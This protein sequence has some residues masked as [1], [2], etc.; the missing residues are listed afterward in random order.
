MPLPIPFHPHAIGYLS[1]LITPSRSIHQHQRLP[2]RLDRYPTPISAPDEE[3]PGTIAW[4][5]YVGRRAP[6]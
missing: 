6:Y 4:V 2:Q 1:P 5:N 3:E